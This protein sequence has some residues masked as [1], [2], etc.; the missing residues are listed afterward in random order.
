MGRPPE[1]DH[2]AYVASL[3]PFAE[4][5][6]RFFGSDEF[7]VRL[8]APVLAGR[9]AGYDDAGVPD[10]YLVEWTVERF[11]LDEFEALSLYDGASSWLTYYLAL[12]SAPHFQAFR[13]QNSPVADEGFLDALRQVAGVRGVLEILEGGIVRGWAT[14]A[15]LPQKPLVLELWVNGAFAASGVPSYFRRDVQAQ[16]GGDGISGFEIT[17]PKHYSS[18]F[19]NLNIELRE[20]GVDH[21][22]ARL[23]AGRQHPQPDEVAATRIE[24]GELRGWLQ[25]LEAHLPKVQDS[26]TWPLDDYGRYYDEIYR[27]GRAN[28]AALASQ[29]S[30]V[31]LLDGRNVPARWLEDAIWSLVEQGHDR[32]AFIVRVSADQEAVAVDIQNR[33]RWNSGLEFALTISRNE[34]ASDWIADC[35]EGLDSEFD[36]VQLMTADS[37]LDENTLAW[38]ARCFD[39]PKIDAAY[40]DE[41]VFSSDSDARDFR[42]R[43]HSEPV[44]KPAFDPDMLMQTPYV[45]NLVA[46]RRSVLLRLVS[47]RDETGIANGAEA[48]LKMISAPEAVAHIPRVLATRQNVFGPPNAAWAHKVGSALE[49]MSVAEKPT[50]HE[51][52]L[53]AHVAGAYRVRRPV[54]AGVRATIIVPTRDSLE[55]LEPCLKSL[56]SHAAQNRTQMDI[57]VVDHQ[58][59]DPATLDYLASVR[60]IGAARVESFEGEFNWALMNNLAAANSASEVLVFLNNDTI[61]LSPDWLDELVSQAMRPEVGVVG[62]RLIY[63][64]GS[65]QHA[66]FVARDRRDIFVTHEG[67]GMAGADS[68]Y[69]GRNA[70]LRS[71]VA[72]TGA[73]M[74]VRR[75]VFES[76]GGFDASSFPTDGNDVD[77]CLRARAVGLRVLYDPYATLYHLE[78]QTRSFNFD[79]A[80]KREAD[81]AMAVLWER[82]GELF[83]D[84]PAF[85]AHF[86]R[87]RRP[88]SRLRPP[89]ELPGHV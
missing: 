8:I 38:V 36:I 22:I 49:A 61:V 4:A 62:C 44:L 15:P 9:A 77:F 30:I 57:V 65:L 29:K 34:A 89:P 16:Y 6:D 31:I 21:I 14:R 45:G 73:C 52:I 11:K 17:L 70:L 33:V 53:G 63:A 12:F 19:P 59:S 3:M 23:R 42:T 82:W 87:G 41:D 27:K 84:D 13:N 1:S 71:A 72:V 46:L 47:T 10:K 35:V 85:N 80:R 75:D 40:F 58:S 83:S 20:S 37:V 56:M 48:L 78:S 25:R 81:R 51:D 76:L 5:V 67:V 39:Q 7:R 86:D 79:A 28:D 32:K 2:A 66:G 54:E 18:G 88:F 50:R 74:A 43:D 24:L 60:S 64:D 55:L 26:L 69:L 68:G